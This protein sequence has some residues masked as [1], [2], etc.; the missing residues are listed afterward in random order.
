MKV[1]S[2]IAGILVGVV[3]IGL[4]GSVQATMEKRTIEA[5]YQD[6]QVSLNGRTLA[7]TDANGQTVEPF[8]VNGTTYLP[9]R[10]VAENLGLDVEWDGDTATVKLSEDNAEFYQEGT[11]FLQ[12]LTITR[13]SYVP[14]AIGEK[15]GIYA[16]STG[17]T[18]QTVL[19]MQSELDECKTNFNGLKA[20]IESLYSSLPEHCTEALKTGLEYCEQLIEDADDAI[21]CFGVLSTDRN[22]SEA[23]TKFNKTIATLASDYQALQNYTLQYATTTFETLKNS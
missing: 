6:I 22:S 17:H 1:K 4:I 15:S 18:Y 3:G 7:L 8:A 20:S 5:D 9:V 12:L 21:Y 23:N 19:E 14:Y 10:A 2:F 11:A 16:G 13:F